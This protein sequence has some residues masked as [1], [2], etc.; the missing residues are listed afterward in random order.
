MRR[1]LKRRELGLDV[2][3]A[4]ATEVAPELDVAHLDPDAELTVEA[5][6]DSSGE[7]RGPVDARASVGARHGDH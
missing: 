6:L 5:D 3:D 1:L 2:G 7:Q 4:S